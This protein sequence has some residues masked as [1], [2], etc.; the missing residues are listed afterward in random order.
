MGK[1]EEDGADRVERMERQG[2]RAHKCTLD[3]GEMMREE[4]M[5]RNVLGKLKLLPL[6]CCFADS[7]RNT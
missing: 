2:K 4:E 3:T 7:Y 5:G 6:F 1:E